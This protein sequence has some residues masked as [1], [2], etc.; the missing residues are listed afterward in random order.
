MGES[1]DVKMS[2]EILDALDREAMCAAIRAASS[3]VDVHAV[4]ATSQ[5]AEPQDK[6]ASAVEAAAAVIKGY[7]SALAALGVSR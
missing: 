4:T 2:Q 6:A 1:L 7:Q 5:S 3:A